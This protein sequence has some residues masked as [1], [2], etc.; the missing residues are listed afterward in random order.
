MGTR[1]PAVSLQHVSKCFPDPETRKPRQVV[2]C[3][4]DIPMRD[5]VEQL[6]TEYVQRAS[7]GEQHIRACFKRLRQIME[8]PVG[9]VITDE[10]TRQTYRTM[11]GR[12]V[13]DTTLREYY[14]NP[15]EPAANIAHWWDA[16]RRRVL[17]A[18][19]RQ[20][21]ASSAALLMK[22][23]PRGRPAG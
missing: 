9:E 21:I 2:A 19:Q 20:G 17:S 6:V 1:P 12:R 8:R 16:V 18:L 3:W 7:L 14:T 13:G 23:S 5:L 4:S 15:D 11:L 10:K 22:E